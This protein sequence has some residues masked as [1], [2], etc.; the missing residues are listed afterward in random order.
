MKQK[1]IYQGQFVNVIGIYIV[2]NRF[3]LIKK[4][5]QVYFYLLLKTDRKFAENHLIQYCLI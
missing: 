5:F 4:E 3:I 2:V 1:Q